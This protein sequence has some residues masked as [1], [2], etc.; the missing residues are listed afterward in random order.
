[1]LLFNGKCLFCVYCIIVALLC[2]ASCMVR[3]CV[4]HHVWCV[5]VWCIMCGALLCG[6]SWLHYGLCR[7]VFYCV[8]VEILY[9][10]LRCNYRALF[11]GYVV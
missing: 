10:V 8:M 4:V 9:S 5:I 3:Y 7:M 11:Y 6:A 2:G 1:M